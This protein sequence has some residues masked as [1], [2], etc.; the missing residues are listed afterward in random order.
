MKL[1]PP[2]LCALLVVTYCNGKLY[3]GTDNSIEF[4]PETR[5]VNAVPSG[6]H[7]KHDLVVV[8]NSQS[9]ESPDFS[10]S[11]E[12]FGQ[13]EQG[14]EI[15]QKVLDQIFASD[16]VKRVDFGQKEQGN[17]ID[18]KV[19]DQIFASDSVKRVESGSNNKKVGQIDQQQKQKDQENV[20]DQQTLDLCLES[21]GSENKEGGQIDEQQKN[22]DGVG[23]ID[24]RFNEKAQGVQDTTRCGQYGQR[25]KP[26]NQN[27]DS[28]KQQGTNS[29]IPQGF[30]D[31]SKVGY[32]NVGF[33]SG[34]ETGG[35]STTPSSIAGPK[36]TQPNVDPTYTIFRPVNQ[37]GNSQP[38][39]PIYPNTRPE[40]QDGNSQ[41]GVKPTY[42]NTRPGNQD[43][44]S[45]PGVNPLYPIRPDNNGGSSQPG[46]IPTYPNRPGNQDGSSQPGV[47]PTYPNRPGNQ[48]GRGQTG[49]IS[50][51]P[52]RPGNQDGSSLPGV[53]PSYPRRPGNQGGSSQP[54][55]NP[56]YPRRPGN[57]GGSSQPGVNPSYPRRPGNQGGSGQRGLH[58][59]YPVRPDHQGPLYWPYIQI[60][61]PTGS[62]YQETPH[63]NS[64]YW[65]DVQY[66]SYSPDFMPE[67]QGGFW[68]GNGQGFMNGYVNVPEYGW[69]YS[70]Y[71]GYGN[72]WFSMDGQDGGPH[73]H[74]YG[75]NGHEHHHSHHHQ[76]PG[77][78]HHGHHDHFNHN[79]DC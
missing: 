58:P 17:E 20:I 3:Y 28:T 18:Q 14:N 15:D 27:I 54:G 24:V 32:N 22:T 63:V 33:T 19:F 43:G 26:S 75:F 69:P 6:G 50:T 65:P 5:L 36:D 12:D 11:E 45:Q 21:I 2:I 51:Y 74:G 34:L 57:Q 46:V 48:G 47:I 59:N 1:V 66:G 67:G 16:S 76:H 7:V 8:T 29:H 71:A 77:G 37:G 41:P 60:A 42:P 4:V 70:Q 39:R 78:K 62:D 73:N 38:I 56:S 35:S 25:L 40:N 9:T 79:K 44:S 53:N 31:N 30:G 68:F 23:L 10:A 72:G 64:G 49:V 61:V 13:K 52:I 55:V